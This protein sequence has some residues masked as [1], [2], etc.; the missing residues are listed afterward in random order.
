[1]FAIG[2]R[3]VCNNPD[4]DVK[5]RLGL[6]GTVSYLDENFVTVSCDTRDGVKVLNYYPREITPLDM[7]NE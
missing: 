6:V 5:E 4:E 3:V 2:M 7:E 1:M